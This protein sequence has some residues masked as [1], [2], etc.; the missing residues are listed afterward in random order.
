MKH[1]ELPP[2]TLL[3][4]LNLPEGPDFVAIYTDDVSW[5][6]P[7]YC[8]TICSVLSK[9]SNDYTQLDSSFSQH[10]VISWCKQVEY[11]GHL[12]MP[13]GL[14]L[15][16][17][18]QCCYRVP[19]PNVCDSGPRVYWFDIVLPMIQKGVRKDSSIAILPHKGHGVPVISGLPEGLMSWRASLSKHQS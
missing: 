2:F 1:P 12:I 18:N 10:S 11:L 8:K 5:Y 6:F 7:R 19:S 16:L 13:Q 17:E 3:N 4:C 15:N 9:F 14:K